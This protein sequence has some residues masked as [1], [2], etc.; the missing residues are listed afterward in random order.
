MIQF[1]VTVDCADP[2]RLADFWAPALGYDF[3]HNDEFVRQLLDEG[4]IT[5]DETVERDGHVFFTIARAINPPADAGPGASRV[6]FWVVPEGK[7]VKNRWH[8]DLNVGR[9]HVDEEVARLTE[10]G[11]AVLYH[12]DSREGVHTTMAD[13]EGNEFCVQ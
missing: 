6:L 3:E 2:H 13:P 11:A 7:T 1:Q 8:L 12:Q 5:S 10:L 9:D 4:K